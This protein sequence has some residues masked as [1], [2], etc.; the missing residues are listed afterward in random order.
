MPGAGWAAMKIAGVSGAGGDAGCLGRTGARSQSA[1][2]RIE[3]LDRLTLAADHQ[4]VAALESPHAA[5]CSHVDVM[6][7]GSGQ[8]AGPLD[9]VVIMRVAAVD[10]DVVRRQQR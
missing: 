10:D 3:T 2:D 8:C 7:S 4:A 5:R 1:E 9:V 6:D